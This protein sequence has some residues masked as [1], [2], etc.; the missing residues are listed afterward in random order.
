MPFNRNLNIPLKERISSYECKFFHEKFGKFDAPRQF[1][2][3]LAWKSEE[4]KKFF[5]SLLLNRS[6]GIYVIVDVRACIERL[7]STGGGGESYNFFKSILN[8]GHDYIVL[9]GNNRMSFIRS[10]FEDEYSIPIGKHDY[11][12]DELNG[13]VSSF[14]VRAGRQKFS[15]LPKRVQDTL[16]KRWFTV[17]LYTQIT[18]DGMSETFQNVN[19]GVALNG[20]ELRNAYSTKW[21][22]Y[23][24]NIADDACSLL[25]RLFKDPRFR[26]KGEEWIVDCLD[27]VIQA[28]SINPIL[29]EVSTSGITQSTKNKLYNRDF[30][31]DEDKNLYSGKFVELMDFITDMASEN[32]L[33]E[34]TLNRPSTVQNLYWMMCNGIETYDQA[35]SAIKLHNDAYNDKTRTF[36]CGDDEKTFKE[37]CNGMSSENLKVRYNIFSEIIEKVKIKDNNS[38]NLDMMLSDA[39][40]DYE[41]TIK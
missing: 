17:S 32:I 5:E 37:C 11:I 40:I 28:I 33:D 20:Q 12:T 23:V 27:L 6:E 39:I 10:M 25:A 29:N 30:L 7:E 41:Q 36:L 38:F 15:D 1:Q 4:R 24:R 16:H 31:D 34:K 21:S 14:T 13:T 9:D 26:L 18:L 8:S 19:S 3:P 22:E 35:V 2:R